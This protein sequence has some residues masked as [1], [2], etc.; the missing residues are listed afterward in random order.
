LAPAQPKNFA[1]AVLHPSNAK[2][3]GRERNI[4][5]L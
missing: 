5:T 4:L 3:S 2:F 1:V